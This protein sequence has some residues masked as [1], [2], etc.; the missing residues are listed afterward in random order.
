M[1]YFIA[2]RAAFIQQWKE[3]SNAVVT[4]GYIIGAIPTSIVAAWVALKSGRPEVL[5]YLIVAAPLIHVWRGAILRVG[6]SLDDELWQRTLEPAFISRTPIIVAFFGKALANIVFGL[7]AGIAALLSMLVIIRQIPAIADVPSLIISLVLILLSISVTSILMA[8]MV[9]LAGGR[10][11]FFNAIMTIGILISGFMVP[12]KTLPLGFKIAARFLPTSWAME[13]VWK[14]ITGYTSYWE[15]L[16]SWGGCLLMCAFIG[17][18]T[19]LMFRAV[20]QRIRIKGL[21]S[22]Y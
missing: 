17:T 3:I 6:W 18:V 13:G 16:Q 11:G 14:S 4:L 2:I 12:I 19:Y 1:G 7:P 22:T 8:P 20:E 10:G 9:I 5:T 15:I 21:L